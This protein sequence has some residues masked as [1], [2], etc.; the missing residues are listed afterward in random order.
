MGGHSEFVR[1]AL[2]LVTAAAFLPAAHAL[3]A[4]DRHAPVPVRLTKTLAPS[5]GTQ[6]LRLT[7]GAGL[8][9]VNC[10][11]SVVDMVIAGYLAF[12]APAV[13]IGMI[14]DPSAMPWSKF[15]IGY[16]FKMPCSA[17]TGMLMK[18]IPAL[19][20]G[21]YWGAVNSPDAVTAVILIHFAKRI[22]EVLVLHDFS[23]SPTEEGPACAL[24]GSFYAMVSWLFLRVGARASPPAVTCGVVLSAV[25]MIGN[26]FHHILLKNL[27]SKGLTAGTGARATA[28]KTYHVP[29][30][31]LFE[32]VACPHYLFEILTFAGA[33]CMTQSVH[34]SLVVFWVTSML[35]ARS[36]S[37]TRWY[38]EK[39]GPEYPQSRRH[40]IPFIF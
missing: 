3:V 35:T 7:G 27:R 36:V 18:Y 15:A 21:F 31:G 9:S 40:I 12:S 10:G 33:A 2:V 28:V 20:F 38:V 8:S 37:T 29:R 32:F 24:I 39:F 16:A 13:A 5:T 26:L 11:W 14:K 6:V 17:R 23:G 1:T 25:G 30:G 22:I 19:C 4:L 34:T